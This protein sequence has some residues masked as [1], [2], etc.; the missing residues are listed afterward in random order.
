MVPVP[1]PAVPINIIIVGSGLIGTAVLQHALTNPHVNHIYWVSRTYPPDTLRIHY[2]VTHLLRREFLNWHTRDL[3]RMRGAN[4]C[5]WALGPRGH[6]ERRFNFETAQESIMRY[7]CQAASQFVHSLAPYNTC[8]RPFNFVCVNCRT[9]WLP[10]DETTD[11]AEATRRQAQT[12]EGLATLQRWHPL[13][14]KILI[15]RPGYVMGPQRT[16]RTCFI[17][18]IRRKVPL[19]TVYVERLAESLLFM[20]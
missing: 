12:E 17:S 5:I 18:F 8:G 4:A 20:S 14:L 3:E 9:Q 15:A 19:R 13:T 10:G 11:N 6:N 7:P 1:P 2:K 16:L